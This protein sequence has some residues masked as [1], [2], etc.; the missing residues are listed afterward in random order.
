MT[1]VSNLS[2]QKVN[3]CQLRVWMNVLM[4]SHSKNGSVMS[5]LVIL[6]IEF[7]LK[8]SSEICSASIAVLDIKVSVMD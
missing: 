7:H 8:L 5:S 3:I 4:C 1:Q 2:R 6:Y